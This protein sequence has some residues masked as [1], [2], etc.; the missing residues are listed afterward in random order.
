ML[1][2][3]VFKTLI[4]SEGKLLYVALVLVTEW[5]NLKKLAKVVGV[6]KFAL[7]EPHEVE[8]RLVIF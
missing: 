3:Q 6:K 1:L 7:A 4:V 8:K 2:K 5:L